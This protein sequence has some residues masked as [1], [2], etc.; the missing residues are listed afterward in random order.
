MG[1]QTTSSNMYPAHPSG[2]ERSESI[3][4]LLRRLIDE[5]SVLFRKEIALA[6]AEF[7]EAATK[8]KIGAVTLAAGGAVLFLGVLVL[9]AAAVLGLAKVME[10]WLAALLVGALV[11]IIG[12]VMVLRGKKNLEPS[13]LKPDRTQEALRKDKE[14]VQRRIA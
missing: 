11:V 6:K 1:Q 3:A 2:P 13:G 8:A 12:A 4:G 7:S 5:V 9:L 14:M 10:A